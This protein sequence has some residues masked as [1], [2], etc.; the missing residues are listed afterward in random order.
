MRGFL[1]LILAL[2]ACVA[3]AP[4]QN[5]ARNE[6]RPAVTAE[7]AA[8]L[9]PD[10]LAE[11]AFRDLGAWM[12]A[13]SRPAE[14]EGAVFPMLE[15]LVFAGAPHHAS[16]GL[17]AAMR[18][19]VDYMPSGADRVTTPAQIRA[20]RAA[21]VYKV[22]GDVEPYAEVTEQRAAEETRRCAAAGPVIPAVQGDLGRAY[23]FTFEGEELPELALLVLQQAIVEAREGRY[24][25]V[26]CTA[27]ARPSGECRDPTA[28][29]GGLSLGNLVSL[30][31]TPAGLG[32]NRSVIRARFL[33]PGAARAQL[34]RS[35]AVEADIS[36]PPGEAETIERLGRTEIA[37]SGASPD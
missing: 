29:L 28:L 32:G 7:K 33:I 22:T 37:G 30:Q 9:P 26:T 25:A 2:P 24:R 14:R 35:V 17:C 5:D 16:V 18:A 11:L 4:A 19:E 10:Q 27:A 12:T 3:P 6:A 23:Y 34:Y 31:V 8:S 21:A 1:L 20:V 15:R 13:V 36:R